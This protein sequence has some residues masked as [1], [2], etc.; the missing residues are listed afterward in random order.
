MNKLSRVRE[1]LKQQNWNRENP[2]NQKR[3]VNS[4]DRGNT[5]HGAIAKQL[6]YLKH[7]LWRRL[8]QQ[9]SKVRLAGSLGPSCK[10]VVNKPISCVKTT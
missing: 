4:R 9:E 8:M 6:N 5:K 3:T 7:L 10:V 2:E 1:I